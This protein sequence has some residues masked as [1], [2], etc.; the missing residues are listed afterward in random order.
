MGDRVNEDLAPSA[1]HWPID[2]GRLEVAKVGAGVIPSYG[3][4]LIFVWMI[5]AGCR[6]PPSRRERRGLRMLCRVI[7]EPKL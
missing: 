7:R 6:R 3:P 4:G 1:A 5:T 2:F